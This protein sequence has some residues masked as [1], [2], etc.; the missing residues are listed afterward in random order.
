MVMAVAREWT[1]SNQQSRGRAPV[2]CQLFRPGFA[3]S[4][5]ASLFRWAAKSS[6]PPNN[7]PLFFPTQHSPDSAASSFLPSFL[8]IPA[9][10]RFVYL[11]SASPCL[12]YC[13]LPVLALNR[14][15][16]LSCQLCRPK[17]LTPAH[18]PPTS[19]HLHHQQPSQSHLFFFS[20]LL[21]P[22]S[23]HTSKPSRPWQLLSKSPPSSL[24]LLAMVVLE[25]YV[26]F[27]V[28]LPRHPAWR[29]ILPVKT[30]PL[31]APFWRGTA[32]HRTALIQRRDDTTAHWR[33]RQWNKIA[34]L[35]GNVQ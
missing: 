1:S 3:G 35:L 30:T 8:V 34:N 26:E 12:L 17:P 22:T 21:S 11:N 15:K 31:F 18:Q 23:N 32:P 29:S 25:R 33:Q 13:S 4:L 14:D 2:F 28:F 24:C 6:L 19:R 10:Q 9:L 20:L 7:T 27:S 5:C 16:A